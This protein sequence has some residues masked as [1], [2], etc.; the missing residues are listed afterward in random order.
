MG[1]VQVCLQIA[2]GIENFD[3]DLFFRTYAR[4]WL[5]EAYDDRTV[6]HY[7]Q[8]EHPFDYLRCNV[9]LCQFEEFVQTYDIQEGDGM[10]LPPEERI[11]IW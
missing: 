10:Y 4:T 11:A 7:L 5:S 6:E 9:T 8:D 3:Y 2:K 1:G